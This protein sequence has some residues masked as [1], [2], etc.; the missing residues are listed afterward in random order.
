MD[1][2]SEVIAVRWFSERAIALLHRA[3]ALNPENPWA[4][5]NLGVVYLRRDMPNDAVTVLTR[6]TELG[7]EDVRAWFGLAQA[8]ELVGETSLAD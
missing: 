8:L 7:P 1:V 6:A 4:Y 3:L 5:R 2:G